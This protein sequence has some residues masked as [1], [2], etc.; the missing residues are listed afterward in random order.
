MILHFF[1]TDGMALVQEFGKPD[2]FITM[3]ASAGM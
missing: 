2:L 3:T 1:Y